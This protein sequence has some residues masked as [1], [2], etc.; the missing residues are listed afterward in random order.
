M[1]GKMDCSGLTDAGRVRDGND[2]QYLIASLSKSMQVHQTSLDLDEQTRLF[3]ASQ[4][5]LLLVA[6]GVGGGPAGGRRASTLAVNS[7]TTY[8]LNT[9]DWFFRLRQDREDEFLGEL[10]AALEYCQDRIRA[11]AERIPE[12]R[13]MGTTLTLAYLAWPRLYVVHA[14]DSRCYL[15][16]GGRLRQLTR[17]HALGGE[18]LGRDAPEENGGPAWGRVLWNV[19]G[20]SSDELTV[21]VYRAELTLGDTL[22]LCTDG[23][24]KQVPDAQIARLLSAEVPSAE[25]CRHLVDA[26]N[27]A[28]GA[29]NVTVVVAHFR[30]ARR[31]QAMQEAA[32]AEEEPV[33]EAPAPVEAPPETVPA[34]AEAGAISSQAE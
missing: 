25:T 12:R 5:K 14:G 21:E 28:G 6:D 9:M 20:G 31:Q 22:L 2:D 19:V 3:G 34:P 15:L 23:L 30:D 27:S 29:D 24:T 10:K 1:H 17:D 13:G 16:R 7:L 18:P 8:L 11:E 32:E 26:A 33:R 4:G